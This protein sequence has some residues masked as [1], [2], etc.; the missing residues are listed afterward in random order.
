M[1]SDGTTLVPT[2]PN[3]VALY[4]E[5][6]R[7]IT[8]AYKIDEVKEIHDRAMAF[9]VYHRQALNI[10][11]ERQAAEIRIRAERR[12]GILLRE[13][14]KAKGG[15]PTNRF[16]EATGFQETTAAQATL[17]DLGISKH[18]SMDWQKLAA[19]PEEIFEEEVQKYGATTTNII[20]TIEPP[21]P[22]DLIKRDLNRMDKKA[23]NLW[24][25]LRRFEEDYLNDDP[26]RL[27][28]AMIHNQPR[29]TL[30]LAPLVAAWLER[31][32]P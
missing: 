32:V 13:M 16:A 14:Q 31:I 25:L 11:A 26:N 1:M 10:D 21:R 24:G 22:P 3:A 9:E 12:C 5:M 6:C 4:D 7:A 18:Q 27:F 8:A 28:K 20:S 15:R 17:S 19:V 2:Q 30:R 23:L 29:D